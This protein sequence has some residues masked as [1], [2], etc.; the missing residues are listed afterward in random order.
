MSPEKER[1][2][3]PRVA[4]QQIVSL[5]STTCI[6]DKAALTED[7]SLGGVLLDTNSC[8]AEGAEVAVLLAL[9]AQITR[10]FEIR[11]MC[12]GRVLRRVEKRNRAAVAIEFS[13][14]KHEENA[15][16]SSIKVSA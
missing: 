10:T 14:P 8:V 9:P 2:L 15:L 16:P 6:G 13:D 4:V 3:H 12:R 7:I 1:R 5:T 11:A